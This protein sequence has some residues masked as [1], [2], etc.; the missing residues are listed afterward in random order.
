MGLRVRIQRREQ[1]GQQPVAEDRALTS[2]TVPF[3]ML[4]SPLGATSISPANPMAVADV[5]AAVRC[6]SDAAASI[7]LIPYRKTAD[8]RTRGEGRLADLLRQPAPATTQANLVGPI[9]AHLNL[10]GNAYLGLFRDA[11]GKVEQL[12]LLHPDRVTPELRSGVRSTP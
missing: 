12:A 10:Y 1:P 8:G 9:V 11:E 3:V 7:P 2:A 5:F 4:S 6:L